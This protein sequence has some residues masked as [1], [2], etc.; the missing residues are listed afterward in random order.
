[1]VA[2]GALDLRGELA[3]AQPGEGAG[4]AAPRQPQPCRPWR[5]RCLV[6]P[7]AGLASR[8]REVPLRPGP[9]RRDRHP[10]VEG[11]GRAWER[12]AIVGAGHRDGRCSRGGGAFRLAKLVGPGTGLPPQLRRAPDDRG[13][14]LAPGTVGAGESPATS[15][16]PTATWTVTG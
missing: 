4:T 2:H 14:V 6:L 16:T 12:A 5:R 7:V 3:A 9:A 8:L 10:S 15:Y 13:P 11:G 1:M